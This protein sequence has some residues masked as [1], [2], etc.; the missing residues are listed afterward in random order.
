MTTSSPPPDDLLMEFVERLPDQTRDI[1]FLQVM[2]AMRPEMDAFGV[3]GTARNA[4]LRDII[5]PA[6][7]PREVWPVVVVAAILD[8]A[9]SRPPLVDQ[10]FLN[11]RAACG[12][13]VETEMALRYPL[14]SR[15]FRRAQEDWKLLRSTT[16]SPASLHKYERVLMEELARR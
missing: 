12:H 9:L 3:G 5:C 15:Y 8:F 14:A 4:I 13:Q 7:R 2:Q 11:Q 6:G 1:V 10:N 16:L